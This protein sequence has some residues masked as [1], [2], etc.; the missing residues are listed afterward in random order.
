MCYLG[1]DGEEGGA[2]ARQLCCIETSLRV[3]RDGLGIE[4]NWKVNEWR[5]GA[6]K[7][8]CTC[9][10]CKRCRDEPAACDEPAVETPAKRKREE[11][12]EEEKKWKGCSYLK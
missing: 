2:Q 7:M 9:R 11:E 6:W 8:A 12:E 1:P 5:G 10:E 3:S 4:L